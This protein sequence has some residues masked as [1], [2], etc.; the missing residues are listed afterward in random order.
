MI[1]KMIDIITQMISD[2]NDKIQETI[3]TDINLNIPNVFY[4][5]ENCIIIALTSIAKK[6]VIEQLKLTKKNKDIE[7]EQDIFK[8]FVANHKKYLN[9]IFIFDEITAADNKLLTTFD[10]TL[11][12]INGLLSVFL[13]NDLHFNPTKHELVDKHTKLNKD[14]VNDLMKHYNIK[15][16]TSLPI[17][18]KTDPIAKWSGI[19]T[20]DIVKIDRYN[21]NSGLIYYYRACV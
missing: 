7:E 18:L 19:K 11:N 5:K 4:A 3:P 13:S 16:K 10:K 6:Q 8:E 12:K 14:E 2:R 9:Y 20:G 1:E 21:P 15:S 17:M